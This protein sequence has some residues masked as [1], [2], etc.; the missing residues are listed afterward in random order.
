MGEVRPIAETPRGK[1][2]AQT[3]SADLELEQLLGRCALREE[4]ALAEL[5]NLVGATLLGIMM[6]ILR[7]RALA[8]EALQDVMVRVWQHADRYV[9]YKGRAMPWLISIARYR[10]I[11]VLRA[12]R[13][14]VTLDDA[15]A[16]ALMDVAAEELPD[17]TTSQRMRRAL[18]DC[19]KRL[20][21]DQRKCLSLAYIEGYSQDEIATA[22][23]SPLGTVK[24]WVRRGLSSLKRCMDS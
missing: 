18:E 23:N 12:Q 8:E 15:P 20:T 10:A 3:L 5:Y 21:P 22:I 7:S 6:R 24:S 11:D 16:E 1:S 14:Q 19:L 9:A 2:R 13:S 17:T 4:R